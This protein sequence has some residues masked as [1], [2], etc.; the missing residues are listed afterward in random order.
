MKKTMKLLGVA[1]VLALVIPLSSFADSPT[2]TDNTANGAKPPLAK[3]AFGGGMMSNQ[4]GQDVLD[5]LKLDQKSFRAKQAQGETLAQI[6]AD[7]GV[8]RSDLESALIASYNAQLDKQKSDFAANI[9]Q[10]VDAQRKQPSPGDKAKPNRGNA[11]AWVGSLQASQTNLAAIASLLGMTTDDLKTA[12]ASGK[13]L[14]DL[15]KDKAV[16]VQKIIDLEVA[17]ML[18]SSDQDLQS[19]KITQDEYDK[20]KAKFTDFATKMV[21][22]NLASRSGKGNLQ[23]TPM[24]GGKGNPHSPMNQSD[25]GQGQAANQS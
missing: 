14:A 13:S 21:N 22:N 1:L 25:K 10:Y 15:A 12:M 2:S 24:H 19:G 23:R 16:D 3:K 5:L 20:R 6:A 18:A 7:Q 9:D 11:P 8:S 4:I 17:S